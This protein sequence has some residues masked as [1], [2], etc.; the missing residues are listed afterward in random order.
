MD[1]TEKAFLIQHQLKTGSSDPP[2][3]GN[4]PYRAQPDEGT[5]INEK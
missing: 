4:R 1:R 2:S 3:G 5:D